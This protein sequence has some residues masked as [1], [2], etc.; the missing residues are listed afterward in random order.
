MRDSTE[1]PTPIE[2][3][4]YR[5][6]EL[7]LISISN[8]G[9]ERITIADKNVGATQVWNE[10]DSLTQNNC[11]KYFQWWNCRWFN[12]SWYVPTS[13]NWLD[14][15]GVWPSVFYTDI[16]RISSSWQR[17]VSNNRD[18]WW[19]ITDTY[20]ARK[21]PCDN[22]FHIPSYNEL[23]HLANITLMVTSPDMFHIYLKL[24]LAWIRD[25]ETSNVA[26]QGQRWCYWSSS[27]T[28]S[29]NMARDLDFSSTSVHL[30]DTTYRAYWEP[31]R[32]FKN[33]VVLPDNTR[34]KL[35]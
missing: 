35:I 19:D 24:P 1:P 32:P 13:T 28:T 18:L 29:I 14:L 3:G 5:N 2:P 21:W 27:A 4:I 6:E 26:L 33:N 23:H 8:S 9:E 34:T 16:F 22:W 15:S 12:F 17:E 25:N 30:Y 10:W 20:Q 11:W 7:W 31:I